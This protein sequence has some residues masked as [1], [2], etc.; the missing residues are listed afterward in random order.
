MLESYRSIV[1][2][3]YPNVPDVSSTCKINANTLAN[4][5]QKVKE[6]AERFQALRAEY[7]ARSACAMNVSQS[8]QQMTLGDLSHAPELLRSILD[9]MDAEINSA[10]TTQARMSDFAERIAFSQRA[11]DTLQKMH[12]AV[13]LGTDGAN[14]NKPAAFQERFLAR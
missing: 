2:I 7:Q 6:F 8:L 4:D 12:R 11:M 9:S 5:V 13:C 14:P 3:D 10:S 1:E